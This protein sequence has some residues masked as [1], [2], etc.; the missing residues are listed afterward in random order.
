MNR[1]Q[2]FLMATTLSFSSSALAEPPVPPVPANAPLEPEVVPAGSLWS[3]TQSRTLVG[4]DS[5]SRQIGDLITVNISESTE[6]EL[7]AD[8]SSSRDSSVAGGVGSMLGIGSGMVGANS[9][10]NGELSV[11][12]NGSADYAGDGKTSREGTLSGTLTCRV[13][14]VMPNGNLKLWG[15]KEVRSNKETQY[16]I[17]QGLVRPRDVQAD[18]T[19]DSYLLAEAHIEFAGTGT[20]SDKQRPGVAHR[21]LDHAWPF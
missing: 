4:M 19:V 2:Q 6:T 20:V 9:D 1:I 3:E 14:E 16:L 13:I 17:L 18:N 7:Q 21:V 5:N 8:T 15:Y 10:L 12:V 11:S